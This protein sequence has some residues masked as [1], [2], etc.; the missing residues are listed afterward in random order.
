MTDERRCEERVGLTGATWSVRSESARLG[1]AA[2]VVNVS[3]GGAG[4]RLH[5]RSPRAERMLREAMAGSHL[6]EIPT[7][8]GNGQRK[9]HVR[10][11]RV[12]EDGTRQFGIQWSGRLED[13][14]A[15]LKALG[16]G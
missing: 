8:P 11:T 2:E 4:M 7:V 14:E 3:A 1:T 6:L 13:P 16:A 5:V 9:A 15:M 10:W 12:G